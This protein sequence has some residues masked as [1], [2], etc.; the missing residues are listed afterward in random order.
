MLIFKLDWYYKANL[1]YVAIDAINLESIN[2]RSA[3]LLNTRIYSDAN[4]TLH[5]LQGESPPLICNA[6]L[7]RQL[8]IDNNRDCD[9][10]ASV[11]YQRYPKQF[12]SLQKAEAFVSEH[13]Q[14]DWFY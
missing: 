9:Q 11:L 4:L 5:Q 12:E 14:R 10:L 13:R 2:F 7:P 1:T 3:I 8:E 6:R